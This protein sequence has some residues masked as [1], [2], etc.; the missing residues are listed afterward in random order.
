MALASGRLTPVAKPGARGDGG[1]RREAEQGQVKAVQHRAP[2]MRKK[3]RVL[4]AGFCSPSPRLSKS[5]REPIA[6]PYPATPRPE[7][8]EL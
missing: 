7:P 1:D 4:T 6:H 3:L 5:E 8:V 2:I